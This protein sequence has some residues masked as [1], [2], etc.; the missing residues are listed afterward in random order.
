MQ[1]REVPV[2]CGWPGRRGSGE[3]LPAARRKDWGG[4]GL[5]LGAG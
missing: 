3:E 1:R 5:E 2:Q 4:G